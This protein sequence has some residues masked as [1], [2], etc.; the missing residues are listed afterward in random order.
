MSFFQVVPFIK[1]N[2]SKYCEVIEKT[3][4]YLDARLSIFGEKRLFVLRYLSYPNC[5]MKEEKI[6]VY[7]DEETVSLV[8]HFAAVLIEQETQEIPNTWL[9]LIAKGVT[10]LLW[11]NCC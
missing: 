1:R 5:H 9:D 2:L 8:K 11:V 10:Y 6:A 7:G 3:V 4:A